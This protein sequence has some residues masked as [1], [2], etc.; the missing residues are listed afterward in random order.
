MSEAGQT[1]PP[2]TPIE[3]IPGTQQSALAA[4]ERIRFDAG[5][6]IQ[7]R[8]DIARLVE[9]PLVPAVE[10]LFDHNVPTHDSSA[11]PEGGV[12]LSLLLDKM[13]PENQQV[14]NDLVASEQEVPSGNRRF[15]IASDST[16]RDITLSRRLIMHGDSTAETPQAVEADFKQL[17]KRFHPQDLG[18]AGLSPAEVAMSREKGYDP[19]ADG[20][21]VANDGKAYPTAELA[22][23]QNAWLVSHPSEG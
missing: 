14:A 12:Y 13:S 4:V 5:R 21:V 15:E 6:R 2:I 23:K 8:A 17:A 10:V 3:D 22:D 19:I 16:L 11:N 1:L 9:A 18:W 20:Y 7:G